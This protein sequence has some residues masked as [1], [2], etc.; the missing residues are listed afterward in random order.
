MARVLSITYW[1]VKK[2]VLCGIS[3]PVFRR[4]ELFHMIVDY[5]THYTVQNFYSVENQP[6]CQHDFQAT[7]IIGFSGNS[8]NGEHTESNDNYNISDCCIFFVVWTSK[9]LDFNQGE[10]M[11]L[12][13]CHKHFSTKKRVYKTVVSSTGKL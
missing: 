8:N 13:F 6:V 9:N 12:L 5:Y 4:V 3:I 11:N 2:S 1:V 7:Q 10:W